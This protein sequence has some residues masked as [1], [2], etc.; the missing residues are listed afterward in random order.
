MLSENKVVIRVS[1][2]EKQDFQELADR[3]QMKPSQA[4]R[5]LVRETLAVIREN[6]KNTNKKNRPR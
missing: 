6:E 4:I 5:L 1:N 2:L 3:L